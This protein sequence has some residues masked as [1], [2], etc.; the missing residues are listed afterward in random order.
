MN[1]TATATETRTNL[2]ADM[3]DTWMASYKTATWTQDQLET[4]AGSW[5]NQ[6][7]T[8]RNDGQKVL[9]IIVSQT[10]SNADDAQRATEGAMQRAMAGVPGWDLLTR[11]DLRRQVEDLNARVDALSTK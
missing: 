7:R 5:M 2:A 3:L 11:A 9:E 6:A 10:K 8:M 4:L 1:A